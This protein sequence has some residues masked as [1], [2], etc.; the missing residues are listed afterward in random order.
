VLVVAFLSL[1]CQPPDRTVESE[2]RY[3]PPGEYDVEGVLVFEGGADELW[4]RLEGGMTEPEF[5]VLAADQNAGFVVAEFLPAL[6]GRPEQDYVDCGTTE[7]TVTR[8][9]QPEHFNY[10][11]ADS[12][13]DREVE[14]APD[15]FVVR[16]LDRDVALKMRT[17]FYLKSVGIDR[18]RLTLNTRYEVIV[19][20]SGRRQSFPRDGS[21]DPLPPEALDPVRRVASFASFTEG[22]FSENSAIRCRP[23]GTVEKSM[24]ALAGEAP[25]VL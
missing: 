3:T 23:T 8:E 16:D 20:T 12:S 25:A 17:T 5:R 18:T 14:F 22:T 2:S 21:L 7:R 13:R 10:R 6:G 9:G 15:H 4:G 24:L 19:E 1:A 11:V